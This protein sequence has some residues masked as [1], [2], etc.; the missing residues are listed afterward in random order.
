M[1]HMQTILYKSAI[2]LY[3]AHARQKQIITKELAVLKTW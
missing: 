2:R 3:K 1:S